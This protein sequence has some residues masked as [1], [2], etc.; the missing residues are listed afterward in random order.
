MLE[1]RERN[2]SG[3]KSSPTVRSWGSASEDRT[4][5]LLDF[6][7]CVAVWLWNKRPLK[8][9]LWVGKV[10]G[11]W[12]LG[13][14]GFSC[15]HFAQIRRKDP[16]FAA[17]NHFQNGPSARNTLSAKLKCKE[18]GWMWPACLR[19]SQDKPLAEFYRRQLQVLV[20]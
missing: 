17:N 11:A 8:T 18:E 13:L 5:I 14:E 16:D 3:Q 15:A 12:G 2:C 6:F 20:G 1:I 10:L 7:G 9:L 4:L 19:S